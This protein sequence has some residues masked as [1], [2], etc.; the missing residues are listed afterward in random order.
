AAASYDPSQ[1]VAG[2]YKEIL[3]RPG[4][5]VVFTI[6]LNIYGTITLVGGAIYSAFLFWRK[7]ILVNRLYGNILIAVGALMSAS[8]G[9]FVI[10]GVVDWHSLALLLGVIFM[11]WGYIQSTVSE[12]EGQAA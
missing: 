11:Y 8:G 9:T 6:L 3:E 1:P 2:Q 7:Q 12:V 5:I 4:I 10:A